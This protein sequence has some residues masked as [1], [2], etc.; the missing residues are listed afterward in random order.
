M[1]HQA[2]HSLVFRLA[3][4]LLATVIGGVGV[5]GAQQ[6]AEL[7]PAHKASE[8]GK[9]PPIE[10]FDLAAAVV[11]HG[12]GL[13]ADE[14]ARRAR[15]RSPR[16]TSARAA[17]AASGWDAETQWAAFLPQVQAYGQYKRVNDVDNRLS[18]FSASPQQVAALTP[19]QRALAADLQTLIGPS[20]TPNFSVPVNQYGIGVS[21]KYPVSDVFLR[22]WPAY[23]A[24]QRV[25]DS[26][27][28]QIEVAESLVDLEARLAFYDY[29]RA[30]AQLA[31][32]EQAVRQAE[33]QAAQIKHFADAGAV[34][35][36]DLL[37]ATARLEQTRGLATRAHSAQAVTRM[38]LAT[39]IGARAEEVAE[40]A[41][42][43]LDLPPHDARDLG[44]L[45]SRALERRA[46]LRAL[47]KLVSASDRMRVAQQ[48]SGL[49]QL[50]IDASDTY[51]QPN[52]RYLPP[53]RDQLRNSWEIGAAIVWSPNTTLT[54]YQAGRKAEATT[55]TVR[56]ELAIQEDSVRVEVVQAYEE[57]DSAVAVAHASDAQLTAAQ[58]AYRV[59]LE[60]Y[61]SG[62]GV[63]VDLLEADF[64]LTQARLDHAN[65]V[66]GARSALA[67]LE[68]VAVLR[69]ND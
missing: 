7:S 53:N 47:R 63:I 45:T 19:G 29:A 25:T 10:N 46:E 36:V 16:I 24:Q 55:A 41:E 33:A 20:G 39:L 44:Q 12:S 37:T 22:A 21:L 69:D 58:E 57:L 4:S 26:T 64:A 6:P 42:P 68:R 1:R 13:T 9:A 56:A 2:A 28:I 43:V 67:A 31:V 52:P 27:D 3:S 65:S 17:A 60:Q 48:R 59:R 54:G 5:A 50:V 34:G 14:A 15:S 8:S 18:L 30:R 51:S 49:P 61:R 32:A 23:Q 66:I 62:A 38:R 11:H 40:I 35:Q